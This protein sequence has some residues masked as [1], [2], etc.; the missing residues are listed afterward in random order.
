MKKLLKDIFKK[1]A[2]IAVIVKQLRHDALD[3]LFVQ[4]MKCQKCHQHKH[5]C[6]I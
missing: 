1:C 6:W 5:T 2:L 4:N 3:T